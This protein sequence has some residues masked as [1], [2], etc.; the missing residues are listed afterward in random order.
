MWNFLCRAHCFL[1]C[2]VVPKCN[3]MIGG[4]AI[5]FTFECW[6]YLRKSSWKKSFWGGYC[7]PCKWIHMCVVEK[8]HV[9]EISNCHT[10]YD[11][12]ISLWKL[13]HFI[14][15][16]Q[17]KILIYQSW[18]KLDCQ[19]DD[20]FLMFSWFLLAYS[21]LKDLRLQNIATKNISA[22]EI[23]TIFCKCSHTE[24]QEQERLL[25]SAL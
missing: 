16:A 7:L 20:H 8:S 14:V 15:W 23:E 22:E 24:G 9:L 21:K 11:Y 6:R 3:V 5:L 12:Y 4:M 2:I 25:S 10:T 19:D 18:I 17:Q 1:I 13:E